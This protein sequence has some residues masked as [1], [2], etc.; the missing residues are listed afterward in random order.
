MQ[1]ASTEGHPE[2]NLVKLSVCPIASA[3]CKP[4]AVGETLFKMGNKFIIAELRKV[5]AKI[6]A[7]SQATLRYFGW[8]AR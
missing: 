2:P 6:D 7:K 8:G 5:A 4:F 3:Q 1:K